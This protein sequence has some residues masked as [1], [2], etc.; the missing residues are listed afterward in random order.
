[1]AR[2]CLD[3]GLLDEVGIDLVPVLLGEG[4]PMFGKVAD[5][6][7]RLSN[8]AVIEGDGVTH[9]RYEVIK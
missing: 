8:P 1:M 5:A 3:L 2:Q 7:V 9:L 6:P 4:V